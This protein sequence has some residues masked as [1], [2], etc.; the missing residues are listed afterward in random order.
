MLEN[1]VRPGAQ[2]PAVRPESPT[3]SAQAWHN[4]GRE[5][6]TPMVSASATVTKQGRC[7]PTD[8]PASGLDSLLPSGGTHAPCCPTWKHHLPNG[9]AGWGGVGQGR[10][11]SAQGLW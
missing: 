11:G 8:R 6:P 10:A 2:H 7:S 5:L 4:A 3:G 9:R 1:P